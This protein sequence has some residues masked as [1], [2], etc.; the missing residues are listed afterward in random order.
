MLLDNVYPR[1]DMHIHL[2]P[3]KQPFVDPLLFDA[4]RLIVKELSDRELLCEAI[5]VFFEICLDL[6]ESYD[7]DFFDIVMF[8]QTVEPPL[9]EWG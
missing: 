8:P 7:A 4:S 5:V 3:I 6:F 1:S 9:E 2:E